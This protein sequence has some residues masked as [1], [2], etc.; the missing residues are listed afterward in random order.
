MRILPRIFPSIDGYIRASRDLLKLII[1]NIL[2]F[3]PHPENHVC[4]GMDEWFSG[5][6]PLHERKTEKS[7]TTAVLRQAQDGSKDDER[8]RTI[9]PWSFI[10]HR[11]NRKGLSFIEVL[12]ATFIL[13]LSSVTIYAMFRTATVVYGKAQRELEMI[14]NARAILEQMTRELQGAVVRQNLMLFR[15]YESGSGIK[16]GSTQDEVHF[17]APVPNSGDWDLCEV[18]YWLRDSDNTLMRCFATNPDFDFANNNSNELGYNVV[19]VHFY[20]SYRF[21]ASHWLRTNNG[22]WNSNANILSNYDANGVQR[23]PDGLPDAVEVHLTVQDD[24]HREQPREFSTWIY[25]KNSN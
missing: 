7:E 21:D 8:S 22:N 9:K 13:A 5:G 14:Q 12:T 23:N 1:V 3:I 2:K 11:L 19:T 16:T 24:A 6:I 15:G 18:G 25:L 4:K 17:V 10:S 20:Y